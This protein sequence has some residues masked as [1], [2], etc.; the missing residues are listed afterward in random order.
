MWVWLPL[1]ELFHVRRRLIVA[2]DRQWTE[3]L[4]AITTQD[5]SRMLEM[6]VGLTTKASLSSPPSSSHATRQWFGVC[7]LLLTCLVGE[8][9]A[10]WTWKTMSKVSA[11]AEVGASGTAV[12]F[13]SH[14]QRAK[15]WLV[16]SSRNKKE[17][18]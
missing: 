8:P 16:L 7:V 3:D 6:C 5:L 15:E 11:G 4:I 18:V 12:F 9:W 17:E 1:P 2:N 13:C 14:H 10:S